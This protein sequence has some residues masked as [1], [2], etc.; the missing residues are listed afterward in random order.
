[1]TDPDPDLDREFLRR[2]GKHHTKAAHDWS[3]PLTHP[4]LADSTVRARMRKALRLRGHEAVAEARMDAAEREA[5]NRAKFDERE[6]TF[7][8]IFGWTPDG[9]F[10]LWQLS[11]DELGCDSSTGGSAR[12]WAGGFDHVTG[13]LLDGQP[14]ALISQP[15]APAFEY[16]KR[17]GITDRLARALGVEAFE[18]DPLLGWYSD[19]NIEGPT[20]LVLWT[21][22]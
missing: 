22:R 7:G 17:E 8:R 4:L 15:Y 20:A 16:S 9:A 2:S 11:P 5:F 19:D 13:F 12:G 6:Q 18:L 14:E 1:M 21:R 3:L 10:S